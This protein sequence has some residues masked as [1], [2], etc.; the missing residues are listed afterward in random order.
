MDLLLNQYSLN[1][2][3]VKYKYRINLKGWN[4][5]NVEDI[6]KVSPLIA[7]AKIQDLREAVN[8]NVGAVILMEAKLN[9]LLEEE[10]RELKRKKP[11]FIHI[12]LLK[13]LSNDKEAIEFIKK[14]VNPA[15]I[16]STKSSVIK[17]AKKKGLIAIQRIFLIDTKSL[18]SAIESV[19]ENNPDIV[20]VMPALAHSIAKSIKELTNKPVIMAG[21]VENEKQ[22][23]DGLNSGA[24]GV[25]FGKKN[26][27]NMNL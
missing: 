26:L 5:L 3:W 8:S 1:K 2:E 7:T 18:N 9:E 11:I 19:K 14:Y 23:L 4:D 15:G 13:G 21:L 20:E 24:D 10:F 27:W 25:S 22:I 12:D 17:S 16:V 6:L